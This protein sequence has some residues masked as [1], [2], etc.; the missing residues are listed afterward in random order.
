MLVSIAY[1][2]PSFLGWVIV[3]P[4]WRS[5]KMLLSQLVAAILNDLTTAQD[6]ANEYSSQ[7]SRKY[8]KY[9]SEK[10]NIL[11]NFQVPSGIL[12][13]I[14]LDLKFAVEKLNENK[15]ALDI[16]G[17]QAKCIEL[18][19]KIVNEALEE[20]KKVIHALNI[21]ARNAET[22][23][24]PQALPTLIPSEKAASSQPNN[25]REEAIKYWQELDL[26]IEGDSYKNALI[27]LMNESIFEQGKKQYLR[28]KKWVSESDLKQIILAVLQKGV[29]AHEDFKKLLDLTKKAFDKT[30]KDMD[31]IRINIENSFNQIIDKYS[32]SSY[33]KSLLVVMPGVPNADIVV[34]PATLKDLPI[35]MVSTLKI[36]AGLQ[37][38]RWMIAESGQSLQKVTE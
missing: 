26:K 29:L 5:G 28:N 31:S 27:T 11:G 38:Y 13:E 22:T 30:D 3:L 33:V 16:E 35:D 23:A 15:T 20:V 34:N 12:Q 7:L 21:P 32:T 25:E 9:E 19:T 37:S 36:K 2:K 1:L 14:E 6:L 10:D 24:T 8:N 17:T 4:N 18:A